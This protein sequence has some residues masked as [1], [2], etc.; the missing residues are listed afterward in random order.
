[1][2][3]IKRQAP[4]RREKT[5]SAVKPL[6]PCTTGWAIDKWS[7][8]AAVEEIPACSSLLSIRVMYQNAPESAVNPGD[9]G[10]AKAW[11]T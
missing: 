10:C 1:M 4:S 8:R 6:P 2:N 7:V 11:L 3:V 5:G 9:H